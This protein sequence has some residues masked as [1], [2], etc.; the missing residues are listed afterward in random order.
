MSKFTWIPIYQE[1]A[2]KLLSYKNRRTE[3][4]EILVSV[5]KEIEMK[6]PIIERD[7]TIVEDICPFTVFGLFNKGI[8]DENRIKI[9]TNLAKRLNVNSDIPQ[10]FDGIPI[11]NN[12][13]AWFF[14]YKEKVDTANIDDLWEL[15][16]IAIQ[17]ADEEKDQYRR[18][19]VASYDKVNGAKNIGWK[20]TIG[21]FWVRPFFYLNLDNRNRNNLLSINETHFNGNL[22]S[23]K[24]PPKGEDYLFIIEKCKELIESN[25]IAV[26][27]FI[28]FS[29]FSFEM[30]TNEKGSN[31][32]SNAS[33][34]KWFGP[35]LDALRD[36]DGEGTPLQVREQ[37]ATRL[38]LKEETLSEV[39]GKN[40]TKKFDN[41]VAFARNYLVY[42]GFIDNSTH[43][44]WKLT[45][46]GYAAEMNL[47]IASA[48]FK[49]WVAILNEEKIKDEKGGTD[50]QESKEVRYW[51]YAP[52][53][54]SR[55]WNEVLEKGIMCIGWDN[56]G[57]LKEY[58]SKEDIREK[59]REQK[60]NNKSY[61]M[62][63]L[64]TWQFAYEL[65]PGDVVFVKKG[66]TKLIGRGVIRSDYRYEMERDEYKHVRDVQWT[67]Q[68]EWEYPGYAAIKT[69]TEITPYLDDIEKLNALIEVEKDEDDLIEKQFIHYGEEDFLSDVFMDVDRYHSLVKLIRN[70]KN[71]ILQGPPG[72]GKTYAAKR[73][74]YSM[75][76]EK[77]SDRVMMVQFHQSYSYEDFILGFRPSETGFSLA[78]GPFY[79]FCKKAKDDDTRDYF[80]IID[81]I[82]RGNLSKIF[83]ELLMLI[84]NDKRNE[85]LRLLYSNELFSVPK[86]VYIIGM[87]NTADRGLALID[88]ALRRRFAFFDMEPAFDSI[89]FDSMYEIAQNEQYNHLVEKVIALNEFIENDF[90]L[91]VGFKIGHSFLC[92]KET[93]DETWIES[94]ILYEL[95]PLINEYW[96]D[97][98]DKVSQWQRELLGVLD[99]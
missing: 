51:L 78:E 35:I 20:L 29:R 27:N 43:G 25:K 80:F 76:G 54:Q 32:K 2:T 58:S 85:K 47:E 9:I 97:E 62:S 40:K 82:N 91:G 59:L 71:I 92:V 17:F 28:E 52:G 96:F 94:V 36:L 11:M 73:I 13:N 72:V 83:G 8:T 15:F 44:I 57:D 16:E 95:I 55:K 66:K 24:K 21:L 89:G 67:H 30:T 86:N 90:N 38:N 60:K 7:K 18:R 14:G 39:R 87:M 26:S 4:I 34:L 65:K 50:S 45:E 23:L 31:I 6:F 77:D 63:V 84:E 64:A 46:S 48:I 99:D 1:M 79:S 75:M 37:I 81:E 93:V 70:K 74:A 3:L 88:Y 12:L 56:L 61:T 5:Y 10:D 41:E 53:E 33:F 19:F 98:P 42:E 49:K 68:G 69:L 22:M